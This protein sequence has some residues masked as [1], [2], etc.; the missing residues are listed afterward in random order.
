VGGGRV[1]ET[2]PLRYLAAPYVILNR[3]GLRIAV[4]GLT[5]PDIVRIVLPSRTRGV[6][7]GSP[8]AAAL[9]LVPRLR[10]EADV[11]IALTHLGIED[12]RKLVARVPG[13]DLVVGGHS[14]T[15]LRK[16]T[17]APGASASSTPIVQAGSRGA[18][19][20]RTTL[21]WDD[22]ARPRCTSALIPVRPEGGG[23]PAIE[24][25]VEGYRR[26]LSRGLE[27]VVFRSPRRLSFA[28]LQEGESPLGNLVADVIRERTGADIGMMNAGGIRAAFPRGDVT[29]GD[30]MRV[31]PFENRLVVATMR[32]SQV[33]ALLDRIARRI[34]KRG[35][36][37][38]SG[39]RYVVRGD[40][41]GEIVVTGVGEKPG[42]G[43]EPLEPNR[44]YRVAT[45]DFVAEG[46]DGH[47]AFADALALEETDVVL[48]DAVGEYLRAHPDRRLEKDGRVAWRGATK[49]LRDLG[50]W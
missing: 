16:A 45:I 39:V 36:A 30:V 8:V 42:E 28:D 23:D 17:T 6:V 31:L 33:R 18:Y 27:R 19:V 43:G 40:R 48:S 44:A 2:T 15:A 32:G 20:G 34:G 29:V 14:H 50:G 41:A 3:D 10:R 26:E 13:I 4:F 25:F 35:F 37:H 24:A 7:A 9:E 22:G 5:T 46:G 1:P 12:D 11:V 47:T 49:A 21:H 38:F